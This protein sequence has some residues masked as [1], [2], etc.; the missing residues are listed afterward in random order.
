MGT[1][2]ALAMVTLVSVASSTSGCYSTWDLTLQGVL[3]L[4]GFRQGQKIPL[5]TAGGEDITFRDDSSLYFY[6]SDG[7]ETDAKFR[8]IQVS[9]ATFTGVEQQKGSTIIVDL[10]RMHTIQAVEYS[11]KKTA[12]VATVLGAPVAAFGTLVLL[13]AMVGVAGGRPLRVAGHDAPVAA[14]IFWDPRMLRKTRRGTARQ[15][16]ETTRARVFSHWAKEASAEC[17]SI[18]AFLA[19]ARDLQKASAPASLVRAVL[20]AAKEEAAHTDLCTALA[21]AHSDAPI[22]AFTPPTPMHADGNVDVLLQ[23]LALE[24]FWD[25]CIAEGAAAN[26]ARRA[27]HTSR[28]PMTRLALQTIA[29]DESEHA[30]LSRDILAFCLA[31]GGRSVRNALGASLER[32]RPSE[33]AELSAHSL[34]PEDADVD[35]DFLADRGVP[36]AAVTHA[37]HIE[38]WE[39]NVASVAHA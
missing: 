30:Q 23:R 26:L 18:P 3:K 33:E 7:T 34:A 5:K 11:P 19:L 20:R 12:L 9:G 22:A 4:D 14:P 6:A 27:S 13:Y 2:S 31:A 37:A 28:D 16:D 21:N 36:S 10:S 15:D 39:K 35:V 25:G 32:K 38:T 17:A 29:R 1:R 24:A 8:S